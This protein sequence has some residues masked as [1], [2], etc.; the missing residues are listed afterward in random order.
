MNLMMKEDNKEVKTQEQSTGKVEV[1][2]NEIY[3][4]L[5][6]LLLVGSKREREI[7]E[8]Q[9]KKDDMLYRARAGMDY[10]DFS[11]LLDGQSSAT[12]ANEEKAHTNIVTEVKPKEHERDEDGYYTIPGNMEIPYAKNREEAQYVLRY[13]ERHGYFEIENR[14][15]R[16]KGTELRS[17]AYICLYLQFGNMA[18]NEWKDSAERGDIQEYK[19]YF[20]EIEKFEGAMQQVKSR[21]KC[22]D[23]KKLDQIIF[24][25]KEAYHAAERRK[26]SSREKEG[27]EEK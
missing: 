10:F 14:K 18:S 3:R 1:D 21:G 5:V 6:D 12:K 26:K 24:D 2:P 17:L 20:G 19:K 27:E 25:A 16:W 7:R 11:K 15:Y 13:L 23:K 8:D 22:R 9:K 4:D